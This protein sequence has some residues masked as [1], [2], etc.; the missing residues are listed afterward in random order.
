[1]QQTKLAM[2]QHFSALFLQ[3]R[4]LMQ[5][6]M[7]AVAHCYKSITLMPVLSSCM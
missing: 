7:S 4:M 1:V 5:K 2:H 6:K 3:Y